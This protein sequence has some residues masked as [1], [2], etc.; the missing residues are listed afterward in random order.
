MQGVYNRQG[1]KS[2]GYKRE[3]F[4]I[5]PITYTYQELL[6]GII[7]HGY[8][9]EEAEAMLKFMIGKGEVKKTPNGEYV[10]L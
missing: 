1:R 6:D 2:G 4:Y 9:E 7:V 5:S 8:N 3:K 10:K